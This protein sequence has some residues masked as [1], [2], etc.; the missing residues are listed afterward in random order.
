MEAGGG[1]GALKRVF[2][3]DLSEMTSEPKLDRGEE[4]SHPGIRGS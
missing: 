4:T 2:R 1:T 3:G